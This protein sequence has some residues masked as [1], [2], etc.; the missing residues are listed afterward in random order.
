MQSTKP[1]RDFFLVL[2]ER[3]RDLVSEN[4]SR[5]GDLEVVT[6]VDV[7][8]NS[9]NEKDKRHKERRAE[10]EAIT[11]REQLLTAVRAVIR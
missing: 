5:L 11:A 6:D 8:Y 7:L 1:I 3:D 4:E 9:F 2:K 10:R